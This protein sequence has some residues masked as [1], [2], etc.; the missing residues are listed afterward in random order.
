MDE[1]ATPPAT[2]DV[3]PTEATDLKGFLIS[4]LKL[5]PAEGE[6][7]VSEEQIRQALEAA[8][9]AGES[10]G[11]DMTTLQTQLETLQSAHTELQ[12]QH[13]AVTSELAQIKQSASETEIDTLLEPFADRITDDAAKA[14]L[15]DLLVSNREAGMALLNGL[16]AA[17]SAP[18]APAEKSEEPP[19]KPMHNQEQDEDGSPEAR[20]AEANQLIAALRKQR[21]D[22]FGTYDSARNEIRR[23]HPHLFA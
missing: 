12:A 21:P 2:D 7:E 5:T 15:R 10:A 17:P 19:P 11:S 8:T 14:A 18:S 13:D 4:T 6:Q 1:H 9:S 3:T 22:A 20:L 23:T 16:P